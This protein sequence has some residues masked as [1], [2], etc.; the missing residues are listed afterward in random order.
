ME[1]EVLLPRES[2]TS[3]V[4]RMPS[5]GLLCQ[6]ELCREQSLMGQTVNRVEVKDVTWHS[7]VLG[8]CHSVEFLTLLPRFYFMGQ[9]S[10]LIC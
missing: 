5:S 10:H 4:P 3:L 9:P 8:N 1:P 6:P 2:L 7:Q